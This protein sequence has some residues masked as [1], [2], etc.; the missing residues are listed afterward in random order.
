MIRFS[1]AVPAVLAV[2]LASCTTGPA[3]S[4]TDG[5]VIEGVTLLDGRGGAPVTNAR[6]AI[7]H[8]RIVGITASSA[9][10][11][12]ARTIIDGRGR[13]LL[14]GFI[15]MHAHLLFPRCAPG[16]GSL[17]FD[18]AL[19]E[20][21]L[22]RQL[23]FGITTVRSP[24]TPTLDGLGLR[25]D[26]NAG[27]VRGPR[28]FASAE[29]INDPSM[30]DAQLRRTVREALPYRP[31]Y[32]KVYSRLRAEQVASVIA[33][34]HLHNIPVIGHLQR[35]S[36]A[37]GVRLGVDHLAHG[38]DWSIDSLPR[39]A[40]AGYA[41][42]LKKR[43]GFRSR[44]DWLEAF[45][46]D[47]ADQRQLIQTLARQ[48]VSVDVTLIAY[49]GKFSQSA[50]R[51]YRDNPY[52][53]SF[54]DLRSDWER[55]AEAT[56][57]WTV[58]DFA[59]WQ[60]VRPKLLAWIKRMSDGGVLLVSG[61]DVTNEWVIPGE[62]LH[63]E[64]ELLAEAGLSPDRILRMTGASAAEALRRD[65]IGVIEPGRRADLVMLSADPR[66]KISNTRAIVWVMQGGRIVAKGAPR[67]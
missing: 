66:R 51:T 4:E 26:L 24:A 36:W 11:P 20:R 15:D 38:V 16:A 22:S 31:D 37:E 17:R 6:V 60:A 28:A 42:A 14:P 43:P 8:D 30:T 63:Q 13:Y 62:G 32:M 2:L 39:S 40:R 49:G 54:P 19:S 29:L 7:R 67:P 3:H 59:R 47:G 48:R 56:A 58:D 45:D 10:R 23:D 21:A 65:D 53:R 61:T 12:S 34:A 35:T 5:V 46:P 9:V 1:F 27:R 64:F 52:L 57:D 25:D 41:E 18:R 44:I 33:E 50:N 55:C